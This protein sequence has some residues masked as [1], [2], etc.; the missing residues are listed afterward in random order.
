MSGLFGGGHPQSS[1]PQ[2][3]N[4]IQVSSSMSGGCVPLVYG[5]TKLSSN[6]MW[7]GAFTSTP[8]KSQG[9]KGGGGSQTTG[10]NYTASFAAGICE[11]NINAIPN[12]WND[13]DLTTLSALGFTLFT[14]AV[15]QATWSYLSSTFPSQAI[16]YSGV[17]YI[18]AQ[19]YALGNSAAMPNITFEVQAIGSLTGT[20][21]TFTSAPGI[22]ATSAVLTSAVLAN[23]TWNI[24]FSDF[25]VR[26]C[27]VVG[28]AVTWTGGLNNNG[29]VAI[30]TA[31]V[32]G[33]YLDADPSAII[34]NYVVNGQHGLSLPNLLGTI[35]GANS[36]QSYCLALGIVLSPAEVTQRAASDFLTEIAQITNSAP[37]WSA[38]TLKFIPYA[39]N[40]VSG[41]GNTYTP[42]LT[43]IYI[44]TDDDFLEPPE[45]T[46]KATADTFNHVKVEFANRSNAYN[47][48]IAEA[49]DLGDIALNGER[50]MDTLSF[51]EIT[52]STT[53]GLVA[54]LILQMNLYERNTLKFK[55]RPDYCLLEPMDFIGICD[56][57]AAD[58]SGLGYGTLSSIGAV[59]TSQVFQVR[60]ITDTGNDELEI[61]AMEIPGAIRTAAIYNWA[62]V[63][64]YN[65]NFAAAPGSVQAPAFVE[66]YETLAGPAG[67]R[68]LWIAVDGPSGS[69]SWGGC[70]IWMSFDNVTYDQIGTITGGSRYGV[71]NSTLANVA[72]PDSTST[73]GVTLNNTLSVM[74]SGT[75]ADADQNRMQIA[76]GSGAGLEVMSYENASLVSAGVYNLTYLRRGQYSTATQ[77]H[78]S[79]SQFVRLDGTLFKMDLDPGYMGATLYFKFL[80][81]NL[82]GRALQL[83]SGATAYSYTTS[84]SLTA[85]NATSNSTFVATGTAVVFSPT[86][87][88]KQTSGAVAWDSAVYSTQN[89]FNGCT[90]QCTP[91]STSNT[92]MMGLSTNPAASSSYTN[93]A[94]AWYMAP[95]G[96]LQIYESG[97]GI[98]GFSLTYAS[99][100]QLAIVYDGKHVQYF[101]NGILMRSVPIV[102][103]GFSAEF[104]FNT[105]GSAVYGMAFS[106]STSVA[107]NFTLVPMT[108]N[109]VCAGTTVG[110]NGLG[111]NNAWGQRSFQSAQ[112]FDNGV[113]VA[114]SPSI[115]VSGQEFLGFATSPATSSSGPLAA[116]VAAA[117]YIN[118]TGASVQA[119]LNGV[120]VYTLSVAPTNAD[121]YTLTYDNFSYYWYK[122]GTLAHTEYYP[123]VGALYLFGDLYNQ[124][125]FSNIS[126]E[127]YGQLSP[128][129][130]FANGGATTHDS[131]AVKIGGVTSTWDSSINSLN[132]YSTCHVQ[133]KGSVL[134]DHVMCGLFTAANLP[135]IQGTVN[136]YAGLNYAWYFDAGTW[137]IYESGTLIGS[138]GSAVLTDLA[139]I[140][141][142]GATI[143]YLLNGIS[144]R[145]VSVASLLL[146]AGA[147]F[148]EVGSG[149]NNL[150]FGPGV[151][152]DLIPTAGIDPNAATVTVIANNG[153]GSGGSSG[154]VSGLISTG[155]VVNPSGPKVACTVIVTATIGAQQTAGTLGD[156][157]VLVR[158]AD[159]SS[160]FVSATQ[161]VPVTSANLQTYTLQWQ[162]SHT[163]ANAGL[164]QAAIYFDIGSVSDFWGWNGASL[165]VEYIIR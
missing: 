12:V 9:G 85:Y 99:S 111:T 55:V 107:T 150:A 100:T 90:V 13:K 18:G 46:R 19:N 8:T 36:F 10:Y 143:T 165:Q 135:T 144:K 28:T 163:A 5:Q 117:W 31:G 133:F 131:T 39:D 93:L 4:G 138:F 3:Y 152:L 120:S 45:V 23:G 164:G 121:V 53:A 88:F 30:T 128:N 127:A 59:L 109:V 42:N 139:A 37:V 113:S 101:M 91:S 118:S 65:A 43:P 142:D 141:Y 159:D 82:Y 49:T 56:P 84:Q 54:Q 119:I 20:A 96:S 140:T 25:E 94:Y 72:D 57:I 146:Y 105:P 162:F 125:G 62:S 74:G 24:T 35:T 51:H 17:A 77:S 69:A 70:Q 137:Q 2:R 73:L 126:F 78:A 41:N 83:L 15:G 44:F 64:G 155:F 112:S 130:F 92:C 114:F 110:G 47:S 115:S 116:G 136:T 156:V 26:T 22:G 76:V 154:G 33:N 158:F 52:N 108:I 79:N 1:I 89:Y 32:A 148:Y 58:G 61:E 122:N 7:Y 21:V 149:I 123:N 75:L 67:G 50:V 98:G 145:T 151:I 97:A 161:E 81:F 29:P 40:A 153:S 48:E 160:T 104:C 66:A 157:K 95:G 14:G 134:A 27:T 38:G 103:Q 124:I 34:T 63:Q 102:N 86:T 60:K 106:S 71:T 11:G 87:A 6:L 132:N 68:E 129:P 80:S 16:P 147:A